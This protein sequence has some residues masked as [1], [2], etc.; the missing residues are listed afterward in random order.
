MSNTTIYIV[1]HD[2]QG[3]TTEQQTAAQQAAQASSERYAAQGKAVRFVCT[4]YV[5]DK[6]Q[7][8]SLFVT[9]DVAIVRD[10]HEAAGLSFTRIVEGAALA[11][12]L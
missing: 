5:P 4:V 10:L 6:A 7:A 2:V 8:M 1:H 3:L 12:G 9:D 11:P